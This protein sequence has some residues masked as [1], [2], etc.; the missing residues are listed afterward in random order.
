MTTTLSRTDPAGT[1]LDGLLGD[2]DGA[3][4][5]GLEL[6][7]QVA[8]TLDTDHPSVETLARAGIG[9]L[10]RMGIRAEV[11]RARPNCV[12]VRS[13][14]SRPQQ[15][16]RGCALL[17]TW[18]E[19]LPLIV[20]DVG[21]TVV[22]SSCRT[23][24]GESCVHTLLWQPPDPAIAADTSGGSTASS[25]AAENRAAPEPGDRAGAVERSPW[26][27]GDGGEA[28]RGAVDEPSPTWLDKATGAFGS[29]A[30]TVPGTFGP[31][32]EGLGHVAPP[33]PG[34][35]NGGGPTPSMAPAS[36][37][38]LAPASSQPLAPSP[39]LVAPVTPRPAAPA[40][41]VPT[42]PVPVRRPGGTSTEG[43][44][45]R[46]PAGPA[47]ASVHSS[48]GTAPAPRTGGRTS[49]VT[50]RTHRSG[51]WR[52]LRRR[53]VLLVAGLV[54]GSAGGYLATAHHRSSYVATA[55]LVVRSGASPSGPGG[56]NDAEALA[57]TDAAL[58]P[59]DQAVM[60]QVASQLKVPE[61]TLPHDMT[62]QALSGTALLQV[63]F[64]ASS[65]SEAVAGANA[66]A[67]AVTGPRPDDRAIGNG[68]VAL[69]AKAKSATRSTGLAKEALPVG[70]VLGL[71]VGA[72]AALAAERA[73]RRIDDPQ[74]LSDAAG[75]PVAAMPGGL[76]STEIARAIER[77]ARG[78]GV[79]VIPLRDRQLPRA[80]Q[81]AR[82]L[83]DCW[84][85]GGGADPGGAAVAVTPAFADA[86][87]AVGA[88][89]GPTVL[90]VGA[91]ERARVVQEVVGR[92]R[93]IGRAP[94][95]SILVTRDREVD[96]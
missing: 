90:V 31:A 94:V 7:R 11:M 47:T 42:A 50:R 41:P 6:A 79:T 40:P 93:L 32:E 15:A 89:P 14:T 70:A 59:S 9:R 71:A 84:P 78:G 48:P 46:F 4:A 77:A 85:G 35:P 73:D 20:H 58:L 69:V 63:R 62:V 87:D 57:I 49:A 82:E 74:G 54:A 36:P 37:Q 52:W 22:E 81:M 1:A 76:S 61:S 10:S 25:R 55:V 88:R 38:P 2:L 43:S 51:R 21:G 96:A 27:P 18:L 28:G 13:T 16:E 34:S 45:V 95:W 8:T 3:R 92:L 24:G 91:G 5:A 39:A 64:T 75:S 33:A 56:A 53:V 80:R 68:S 44:K 29:V 67:A 72:G 66:V 65:A 86:P 23:R 60:T 30:G 19:A 12:V 83:L 17:T 26:R